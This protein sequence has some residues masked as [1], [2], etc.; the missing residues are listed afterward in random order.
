MIDKLAK[1][2]YEHQGEC[3]VVGRHFFRKGQPR[4]HH[5]HV[6]PKGGEVGRRQLLLVH[7]LRTNPEDAGEYERAKW[8]AAVG[9]TIN[10]AAYTDAKSGIISRILRKNSLE[11]RLLPLSR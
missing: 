3:G 8:D 7:W 6:V 11:R 9:R 1:L 4:T 2:G 5:L 10:S